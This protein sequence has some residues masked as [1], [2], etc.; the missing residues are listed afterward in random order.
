M[1][2]DFCKG[3]VLVS[4]SFSS[5]TKDA[6]DVEKYIHQMTTYITIITYKRP[7]LKRG[8]RRTVASYHFWAGGWALKFFEFREKISAPVIRQ[9]NECLSLV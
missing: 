6:P 3:H 4:V 7:K 1:L 8:Q 2:I 9:L 5:Y